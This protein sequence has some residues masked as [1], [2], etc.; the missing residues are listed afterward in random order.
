MNILK[1]DSYDLSF[2]T[3]GEEALTLISHAS[4]SFDLILLDIM[5]PGLDG[6]EV[7]RRIKEDPQYKDI[8][9]IFLIAQTDIDSITQGF[10]LGICRAL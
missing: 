7:C 3:L 9:I 2:A 4:P 10:A 6:F 5:M 8:P 1:E